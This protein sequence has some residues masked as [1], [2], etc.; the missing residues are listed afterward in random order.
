MTRFLRTSLLSVLLFSSV[1]SSC[2]TSQVGVTN[3]FGTIQAK[4]ATTPDRATAAAEEVL[5]EM[6]M[7]MGEVESTAIDGRVEARTANDDQ[8]VIRT[9]AGGP[10]VTEISIRVGTGLG[11]E[12]LSLV[13]LDRIR[14]KL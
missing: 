9:K 10:D 11:D 3:R 4:L 6:Q 12:A 8:V 1:A 5:R 13:I 7:R 2:E 14:A